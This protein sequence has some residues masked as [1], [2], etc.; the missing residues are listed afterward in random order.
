MHYYVFPTYS[1]V[2]VLLEYYLAFGGCIGECSG[3]QGVQVCALCVEVL[4]IIV[5]P[6]GGWS[7]KGIQ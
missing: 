7:P 3:Q 1:I 2:T 6:S 5:M 4:S